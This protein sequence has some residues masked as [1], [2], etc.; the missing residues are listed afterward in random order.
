MPIVSLRD[1]TMDDP[2]LPECSLRPEKSEGNEHSCITLFA[3]CVH[4]TPTDL[5]EGLGRLPTEL[6]SISSLILF[7]TPEN[8]YKKYVSLDNLAGKEV[9]TPVQDKK[10]LAD[11]PT[12]LGVDGDQLPSVTVHLFQSS[13][14][15]PYV[16]TPKRRVSRNMV[17]SLFLETCPSSTCP[18]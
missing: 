16:I 7:N 6:E 18:L 15:L 3:N 2:F 11:A 4:Y 10:S 13:L 17:T 1:P 5:R 12:T 14:S 8:P 9:E